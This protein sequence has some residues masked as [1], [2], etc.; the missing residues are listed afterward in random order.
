M[1]YDVVIVGAGI[2]GLYTALQLMKQDAGTRVLILEKY[3]YLGGRMITFHGPKGVHWE[4]GAGRIGDAHSMVLGLIKD[5]G[6]H[7]V[8]I[9]SEAGSLWLD[10]KSVKPNHFTE[11][12]NTYMLP[13]QCL[14][15]SVLQT[16]TLGDLLERVH[17]PVK[18]RAFYRLFP[19]WGEIHTLRADLGLHNFQ[20]EFDGTMNYCVCVE[21]LSA[22]IQC[23][24]KDVEKRGVLIRTNREVTN[25]REKD[26]CVYVDVKG[27]EPVECGRC[28]LALHADVL[29]KIPFA[30]E[31]MPALRHLA[32]EPLVRMYAVF[33]VHKGKSWFSGLGKMIT[34]DA[35]RYI[36]PV[37]PAKG[38]VMISYT[39]G[40][41]ARFWMNFQKKRGDKAVQAAVLSH[42]RALLPDIDIPEPRLF[43]IYPW[44]SGCTYWTPGSYD[45]ERM[46][47][48]AHTL[49]NRVYACGESIAMTQCWM[50]GSLESADLVLKLLG[51]DE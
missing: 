3:N 17:G 15:K 32:M 28:V 10:G 46:S 4:I 19:Y 43:K 11:L 22:L 9:G 42:V 44:T 40:M 33:P 5:Y 1:R 41:E 25:L 7:T 51:D 50:E 35:I 39:D 37:N 38:V 47:K 13:L 26:G 16:N 21:G 29:E 23:M 12:M 30:R 2:A 34:N 49:T 20:K 24:V 45:V 27:Q 6:L 36:I 48:E 14:P 31:H 18:A 8:P